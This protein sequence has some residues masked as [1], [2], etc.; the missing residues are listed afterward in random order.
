MWFCIIYFLCAF[1]CCLLFFCMFLCSCALRYYSGGPGIDSRWCHWG[2]FPW[3]PTEPCALRSTQPLKMSTRNLSWG[4]GGRCVWL[5]TTTLVVPNFKK[6]SGLNLPG[7]PW[8]TSACR[9]RPLLYQ[10]FYMKPGTRG[11]VV[12]KAVRYKPA[13]RGFDSRWC[14]WNFSLT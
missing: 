1:I 12:V 11:G 4:K 3:L 2:F 7:N 13:D 9:G 5:T 6:I 8:A 14:H 10:L